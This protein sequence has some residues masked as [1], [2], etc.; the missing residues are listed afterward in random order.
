MD[1]LEADRICVDGL[2]VRVVERCTS[3]NALLLESPGAGAALL[4]AD[5]QTL[6]RGRRGRRWH[7]APG[8]AAMFS[9]R[10]AMACAPAALAG[11]PLALGVAAARALR[12]LGVRG[13]ALKW[14]N[15]LV[16]RGAKLGGILV[17]T[18]QR[19]GALVAVVGVGINCRATPGLGERLR[20]RV[21]VLDHLRQPPLERNRVIEAVAREVLAALATFE[22]AGLAPFAGEWRALHAHEGHRMRVRMTGGRTLS[23]FAAGLSPAGALRLRTR[24][25]V[26][27]IVSGT[28]LPGTRP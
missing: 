17:E 27:E 11:L 6:G 1:R 18:R 23:G 7:A 21:E 24:R 8:S 3:T 13:V 26:R 4:A 15:D 19:A 9:I 20:R 12:G 28:V 22:R 2:Q 10:R 16:A 14:P 25:G 5:E